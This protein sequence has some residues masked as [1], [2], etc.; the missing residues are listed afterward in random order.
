MSSTSKNVVGLGGGKKNM[1]LHTPLLKWCN[2]HRFIVTDAYYI[3]KPFKQ[4]LDTVAEAKR[5]S[6]IDLHLKIFGEVYKPLETSFC[7][8][9]VQNNAEEDE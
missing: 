1:F 8:K 2:K 6:D 4:F 7:S 3:G 5:E 9:L